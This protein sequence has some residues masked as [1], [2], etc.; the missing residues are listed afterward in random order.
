MVPPSTDTH[1]ESVIAADGARSGSGSASTARQGRAQRGSESGGRR[2]PPDPD[3]AEAAPADGLVICAKSRRAGQAAD[4]FAD[5]AG[6]V[7]GLWSSGFPST[8][9]V[10]AAAAMF[11][12]YSVPTGDMREDGRSFRVTVAPGVVA[13]SQRDPVRA[14]RAAERAL[15]RHRKQVDLRAAGLVDDDKA[16]GRGA[17]TYW[18]AKSRARMCRT[19]A[20]LDYGPI[21]DHGALPAM[22][23]LTYPGDWETVAAD[24]ATV[25][26]HFDAFRKRFERWS[27][28][29]AAWVWK[30]EFQ[31]RGAPHLHLWLAVPD[32]DVTAFRSWLGAAWAD[33]VAHPDSEERRRH[34]LAGT[35]VDVLTGLRGSD[36]KRLAI[37]FTKHNSP[38]SLRDKEYQHVVPQ[39][40]RQRGRGP[41]RWW[42][43]YGLGMC[44]I[45]VEVGLD[46]YL[47]ARRIVRRWSRSVAAYGTVGDRFPSAVGPR[48]VRLRVARVDRETGRVR[49]RW[50]TRRRQLCQSGSLNGGFA[51]VNDGTRF[52]QQLARAV[53]TPSPHDGCLRSG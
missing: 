15:E 29:S 27:G 19:L 48:T 23:T 17:V 51:L 1:N 31:R 13:L 2:R 16:G 33:I 52:A 53:G 39:S 30:L 26:R 44:T 28:Q 36:P 34:A 11:E 22:V 4:S 9:L 21:V 40:W 42:G 47:T 3:I 6:T 49:F 8:E 25:K 18:S 20:S 24:G 41:G 37:Y 43:V 5:P 10:G 12:R 32:S 46:A 14:E 7:L 50:T 35:A 45:T 38:N